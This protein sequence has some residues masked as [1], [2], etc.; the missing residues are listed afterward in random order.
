MKQTSKLT[1]VERGLLYIK[2]NIKRE[3]A[4][5]DAGNGLMERTY[6]LSALLFCMAS[7]SAPSFSIS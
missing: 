2:T 1:F 4:K 3:L 6:T 7:N 5:L